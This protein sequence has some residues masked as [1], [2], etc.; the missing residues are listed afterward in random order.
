MKPTSKTDR[1]KEIVTRAVRLREAKAL[2]R[3]R[4][5]NAYDREWRADLK[6]AREGFITKEATA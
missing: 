4:K 1:M 5:K 6:A 2:E 3:K